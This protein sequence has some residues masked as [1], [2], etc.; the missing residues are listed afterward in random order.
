MDL[1][2][3]SL[4]AYSILAY[5]SLV[6]VVSDENKDIDVDENKGIKKCNLD[7]RERN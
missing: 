3:F 2:Q 7:L 4:K 1:I 6:F 5:K